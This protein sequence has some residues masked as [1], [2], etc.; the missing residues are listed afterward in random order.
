MELALIVGIAAAIVGLRRGGSLHAL[1]YTRLR[2]PLLLLAGVLLQVALN[3]W[4]PQW[5]TNDRALALLLSANALV[6]SFLAVNQRLP[7]MLVIA[8]GLALNIT[9]ITANRAMPVS[10]KAAERSGATTAVGDAGIRHEALDEDTV[11]PWLADV[12]PV[13]GSGLVLSVGDVLL[14][15]GISRLVYVRTLSGQRGGATSRPASG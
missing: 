12:I 8:L 3:S 7:G 6:A 4:H 13:P 11:L 9:V 2:A 1:A 15:T 5:L 14:A 10:A